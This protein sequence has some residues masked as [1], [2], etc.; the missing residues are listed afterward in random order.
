MINNVK[1]KYTT[2]A[3]IVVLI[4]VILKACG[5]DLEERL[6]M[7]FDEMILVIGGALTSIMLLFSRDPKDKKNDR[8][9]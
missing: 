8:E 5:V 2:G 1:Q 3:A 7:P 6:N 4:Y 9:D